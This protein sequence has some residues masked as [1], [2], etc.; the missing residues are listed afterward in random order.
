VKVEG[1]DLA[2]V[3]LI[4]EARHVDSRGAFVRVADL[5]T[6]RGLGLG[7][8]TCQVSYATNTNVGTVR[9]MHYQVG[10]SRETKLIWCVSGRALDVLVD[11]RPD[12]PTY[13][14]HVRVEIAADEPTAI[15]AARGLAHGYQTLEP[16][17]TLAYIIDAPFDPDASRTLRWDDPTVGVHWPLA[18]GPI[19]Q[20]DA[21][22]PLWPPAS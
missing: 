8:D 5:R 17:T 22:A 18:L 4:R 21:E 15:L 20:R 9:G 14:H 6:L 19:S 12:S 11:V 13:G 3:R 7:L 16:N 10:R 1:L 2:G